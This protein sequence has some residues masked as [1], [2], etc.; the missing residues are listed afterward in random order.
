MAVRSNFISVASTSTHDNSS[1]IYFV[2]WILALILGIAFVFYFNRLVGFVCSGLLKFTLW[3][4]CKVRINIESIRFNPLGGLIAMKNLTIS[5]ENQTVSILRLNLTWRFWIFGLARFSEYYFNAEDAIEVNG[6]TKDENNKLPCRLLLT[7]DGLEVFMYNRTMAYDNMVDILNENAKENSSFTSGRDSNEKDSKVRFHQSGNQSESMS[8]NSIKDSDSFTNIVETTSIPDSTLSFLLKIFPVRVRVRKGAYV[9]GNSTTPS[10]LVASYKSANAIVDVTKSSSWLDNYRLFFDFDFEK[11]QVAMKPN[12]T[13][14][15]KRYINEHDHVDPMFVNKNL[16]HHKKYKFYYRFQHTTK[17]ISRILKK[18]TRSQIKDDEPYQKWRGLKRYVGE[19]ADDRFLLNYI[20]SVEQYAK[21]SLLLDTVSTRMIYYYDSPGKFP[22]QPVSLQDQLSHPEFGVDLELS[23]A[24]IHYGPWADKQRVPLQSMFFP[25]AARD[26]LPT[27]V[28]VTPGSDRIY[29]GFKVMIT[30]KDEVIFRIP[31]RESSKDQDLLKNLNIDNAN[32]AQKISRPFGWV[33][34]KIERGSSVSSFNSFIATPTGWDNKLICN[35]NGPELRTSVN[36][37]MLFSA[38][39]HIVKCD[40][41]FPLKWDGKCNWT[42]DNVSSNAK[43]FFL[44]EHTILISDIFSDFAS[45]QPTPY[46]YF[47]PFEYGLTWKMEGYKFYLNVNDN[48]IIN[49]PLD[50]NSNKYISFQGNSL[51]IDL[52]IPLY[53]EF[54][55]SSTVDFRIF[56]PDFDLILDTPLWHTANAFLKNNN[57]MGKGHNF[58][59]EG[60]YTYFGGVEVNTSDWIVVKCMGDYITLKFHGFLIKYLFIIKENYM[61]EHKH[62]QTFEEYTNSADYN[63]ATDNSATDATSD[64]SNSCDAKSTK[65]DVDFWKIIKTENDL[66]ILF[67]FQVRNG[68]I[69]LPYHIYDCSS[70]IGLSFERLDVDMRFANYYSDLQADFGEMTGGFIKDFNKEFDEMDTIFNIPEYRKKFLHPNPEIWVDCFNVHAHRMFGLPPDENTYYCKWDFASNGLKIDSNALLL[71][72]LITGLKNFVLGFKDLENSLV[73]EPPIIYDAANFSFRC[74]Y[75]EIKLDAVFDKSLL[76]VDLKSILVNFN[77]IA[78]ARYSLKIDVSIPDIVCRV[79]DKNPQKN[80]LGFFKT[81][82]MMSNFCQKANFYNHQKNQQQYARES[83]APT[84]RVPFIIF[85][86]NRDDNYH[87]GYGCFM[88]SLSL[89][90]ASMPLNRETQNIIRE[91][92]ASSL[93]DVSSSSASSSIQTSSN[94]FENTKLHSTVNYNEDELRPQHNID[95][96]FKNDS[97]IID[98]GEI[99]TILTPSSLISLA[100]I[101]KS[102]QDTSPETLIDILHDQAI[103]YLTELIFPPAMIDNIRLVCPQINLKFTENALPNL[104]TCFYDFPKIPHI[105]FVLYE[106]SVALSK[107]KSIQKLDYKLEQSSEMTVAFHMREVLISTFNPSSFRTPFL[108]TIKDFETWFS[109]KINETTVSSVN[110]DSIDLDIHG[111]QINWLITYILHIKELMGP[112]AEAFDDEADKVNWKASLL[113][114]ITLAADK[115]RLDFDPGVLTK[116]AY[117][118]RACQD[119]V[120]F[121][122]RWKLITRLRHSLENLPEDWCKN[123]YSINQYLPPTAYDEV[124]EF[125][126]NWRNWEAN[127]DER[128]QF[129]REI[130]DASDLN[131]PENGDLQLQLHVNQVIVKVLGESSELDFF[132]FQDLTLSSKMAQEK[133]KDLINLNLGIIEDIRNIDILLNLYSYESKI[134]HI[135]FELIPELQM[136]LRLT[137]HKNSDLK[138][139]NNLKIDKDANISNKNDLSISVITNISSARQHI[140]LPCSTLVFGGFDMTSSLETFFVE[141]LQNNKCINFSINAGGFDAG[142][143]VKNHRLIVTEVYEANAIIANVDDIIYGTKT[144]N[145]EVAK[146]HTK[147]LDNEGMVVDNIV[148]VLDND[149]KYIKGLISQFGQTNTPESPK[150]KAHFESILNKIGGINFEFRMN[151]YLWFVDAL[152][153]LTHAGAVY[154]TRIT[155]NYCEEIGL[156]ES[157]IEKFDLVLSVNETSVFKLEN[158]QI[159]SDINIGFEHDVLLIYSN[160]SLGF[161]KVSIPQIFT[162]LNILLASKKEIMSKLNKWKSI[163]NHLKDQANSSTHELVSPEEA[164]RHPINE[165]LAFKFSFT[166]DYIGLTTNGGK[167]RL[168]FEVEAISLFLSNITKVQTSSPFIFVPVYG[169]FLIPTARIT[170]LDRSVPVGLSNLVNVNVGIKVIPDMD[171]KASINSFTQSLQIESLHCRICVSPQVVICLITVLD[172]IT[173][174]VNKHPYGMSQES[175][176]SGS[177]YETAKQNRSNCM[178]F[179]FSSVH[180]LAYN[181]CLGWLF[182]EKRKDYPGIILGAER[183]F[184]VTKEGMGKLSL[185]DAYLSVANGPTSSNFFSSLTEKNSLNRAFLPTTQL[186]Y[187]VDEKEGAKNLKVNIQGDELDVKFL[188]NSIVLLEYV[189]NSVTKVQ[190]FLERKPSIPE[191]FSRPK[192]KREAQPSQTDYMGSFGTMFSSVEFVATF[193]GSN[194]LFYRLNDDETDNPPSLAL[195][196]PAVKIATMYRYDKQAEKTHIIKSEISTSPSD[197]TL[198]SSC[199]PVITDAVDKVK[200]MMRKSNTN[201][202]KGPSDKSDNLTQSNFNIGNMLNDIDFHLGLKIESQRLSLSCEPTAK[203]AAIVGLQGIHVQVNSGNTKS[204]SVDVAIQFDSMSASLQHIY[205]REVSGSIG[206]ESIILTSFIS[207]DDVIHVLSSGSFSD[208]NGYVNVK[209]FQDLHLFKDIWFPKEAIL[210]ANE[211]SELDTE[212]SESKAGLASNKNISSR[213]REVSTTYAL[214]WVL[215]FMV[216]NILLRVDFGQSLG[217]F[218]LK[219][220]RLWAVS[221]KST[222]WA[223]D[224]K[225]GVNFVSLVS[226]G[227]LGGHIVLESAHL[228]TAI[229]WKL[230][231]NTTL[232]VP[233]ILV[234]GGIDKLQLKVSFDYH[235]FAV[236]NIE[237]YSIDIFNQKNEVSLSK[238][239]LFVTTKFDTSEIYVTSLAAS[240]FID[241]FNTISRMMQENKMSY[242]ETLRDSSDTR[243]TNNMDENTTA[244]DDILETVKKLETRIE[245]VVGKALIQVYP[246]SFDDSKVLVVKMDESKANFQQNEYLHGISNELELQLNDMKVSLSMTSSVLSEFIQECNV[247]DFVE[248]AHKARGGNIFVFPRFMISMRTFQKYKSNLIEYLYQSSFGGTVDIRWNLGSINFIREMYFIHKKALVSRTNFKRDAMSIESNARTLKEEAKKHK[249]SEPSPILRKQLDEDDSTGDIDEAINNTMTKVSNQ[250]RYDYSPIAPPIIEAP[251]LKELGNATPPLEWFGL[252]RNKFPNATHQLGIVSLQK[253]I[254]EVELQYSKILGKA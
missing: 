137:E 213:F 234:S 218:I 102:S 43:F 44:R 72:A 165:K 123:E 6:M 221:K 64:S 53:G 24:T 75:M 2:D 106:P 170:V 217:N 95:P 97:F 202:S 232:D 70:H 153:P 130:F 163:P 96:K 182:G 92:E 5:T 226:E 91:S 48:N 33:E 238:D 23:M 115:Y 139:D 65:S 177:I 192:S 187:I 220:D 228:H 143:W 69:V 147:F 215:S 99:N 151:Q 166:N 167:T 45:G 128:K 104:E 98:I 251:Q 103:D 68:L 127:Q 3:K 42:F 50:F 243:D 172:K 57:I 82:L 175:D 17:Q 27:K 86:E 241:I 249:K 119:H 8:S 4:R 121:Y 203:V 112:V 134:S 244:T 179:S 125:F 108:L 184:A 250:S 233:L 158:S 56:S 78:N 80:N 236:A 152:A 199:V 138:N 60:S 201:S 191:A 162:T 174:I 35:F 21:Y 47:K 116:P 181:F 36:H 76:V 135:C 14:D 240:N 25:A 198:Y 110:L 113:Y 7:I 59:I 188:S 242:K 11:F 185:M 16:A 12:I 129:C 195:H 9:M 30:V 117:I 194:V 10:I 254:H 26:S 156:I 168:A 39:T 207:F 136:S 31:T 206:I 159:L 73:Y 132:S 157:F 63:S 210:S 126:S 40:I 18:I 141:L 114:Q 222:D 252:H 49:N 200:D 32:T 118:L 239:H 46:E 171:E 145:V 247:D 79:L 84:H 107:K 224:L 178:S 140:E 183:F 77:D 38:D 93:S 225:L 51:D 235:V 37:D 122:D 160:L 83:D 253:L 146:G 197:N 67:T 111:E 19:Q 150:P 211:Y 204:P 94:D 212:I 52:F 34:L 71:K 22:K 66:D 54:S 155:A 105:S 144:I 173:H 209:Q 74:P 89:P 227:R 214:P 148:L 237:G 28:L 100:G 245:V 205:S 223:Q 189:V 29:D 230:D 62:F 248:Y 131:T 133:Q 41:G 169:E 109:K 81:S 85:P 13:H 58:V 1:W 186:I 142:L 229:S 61:G 196:S 20:S 219:T 246:S 88:T 231:S 190:D 124:L 180:V 176:E 149:V 90:N 101:A 15:P 164:D 216:L 193:A 208:V 55:K 87:R 154:N 120:R 161:T